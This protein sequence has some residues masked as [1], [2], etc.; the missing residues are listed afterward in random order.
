MNEWK[1]EPNITE[2]EEVPK[3]RQDGGADGELYHELNAVWW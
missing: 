3:R 2:T 1:C